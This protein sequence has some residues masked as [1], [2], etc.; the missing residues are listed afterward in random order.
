MISLF[1]DSDFASDTTSRKS[2]NGFIMMLGGGPVSWQSRRQKSI[3][4]STAEAEYV[5]LF[6]AAKQSIWVKRLLEELNVTEELLGDK[7]VTFTDNQS[8]IAIAKGTNSTKTKHIDVAYH[9]VREC[10]KRNN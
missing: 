9:F 2:V 7:M 10:S 1:S 6:E 3:S 8:A 4:T 5:A